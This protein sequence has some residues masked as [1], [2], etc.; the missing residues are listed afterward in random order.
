MLLMMGY[1]QQFFFWEMLYNSNR[2]FQV[3]MWLKLTVS[4][5]PLVATQKKNPIQLFIFSLSVLELY[6][7]IFDYLGVIYIVV[8]LNLSKI[9]MW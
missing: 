4:D 9:Y 2:W 5:T 8:G 3:S 6:R 1:Y 7:Y